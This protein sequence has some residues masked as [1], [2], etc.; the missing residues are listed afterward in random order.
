MD[1]LSYVGGVNV[2]DRRRKLI[3][4]SAAWPVPA[5]SARGHRSYF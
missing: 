5:V 2:F 1:A 4:A 3:N